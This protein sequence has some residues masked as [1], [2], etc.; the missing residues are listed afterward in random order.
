MLLSGCT[1]DTTPTP[2]ST[3]TSV[4]AAP[5]PDPQ[6]TPRAILAD[7]VRDLLAA[8][9]R[10]DR[11]ASFVLLSRQSRAEFKDVADW[12]GRRQQLPAVTKF[13]IQPDSEGARGDRAGKVV[14]EVEHVPG[15]DPFKGLSPARE[16]QTFTGRKEGNGW[17]VDG[18]PV[19]EPI[20]P[21]DALAIEAATAWVAAVQSCDQPKAG[22]LQAVDILFGAAD[23]AAGLCGK[24]GPVTAGEVGRLTAGVASSDIV[25]QYSTDALE[26]ARVVRMTAPTTFGVVLAP[27]G[28][29]WKVLGLTD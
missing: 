8:E 13:R 16:T 18:E 28:D 22:G 26:W 17:L 23:G 3:A 25:A 2:A 7:A 24:A 29:K 20:L 10:G 12:L 9:Q 5:L 4:A 27:L 11:A 1:R 14:A 6:P 19:T 21:A 15:L